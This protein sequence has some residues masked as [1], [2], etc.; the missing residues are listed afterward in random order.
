MKYLIFSVLMACGALTSGAEATTKRPNILHV[1]AD[2]HR[3]DCLGAL[4]HPVVKTPNLD[5]LV[6]QG[7][8][9]TNCYTMGSMSGAVCQPSRTMMLTGKSWLHIPKRG[10]GDP[11]LSLAKVMS[12][13]GYETWHCGKGGNEYPVGLKA[14][15]VN[16]VM[17]DHGEDK[18]RSSSERH[19]AAAIDFLSQRKADR[20]FYI[21]LAPP[22]PHDPR[23]AAPE[24]HRMYDAAAMPLPPAFLPHH[25]FDNG[26]MT[27]R[28]EKLAP[29]PRTPEDTKRQLADYYACITG[30][31]F[32]VGRIFDQLKKDGQWENTIVIFSGDNGLSIGDHGLFGKQNLY[33]FGGMHV[34]LVLSGPGIPHGT[35]DALVYLMDLFPTL[36]ELGGAELPM[37]VDA[38]SLVPVITGKQAKVRDVL[39]TGYKDCQRSIRD[40]RWKLIRY[41]LV[42][43]TQLFDLHADPHEQTN[44]ASKPQHAAQVLVMM[45]KLEAEMKRNDDTVALTVSRPKPIGWT[46]SRR[47]G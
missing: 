42:N 43:Y 19:A 16:V 33:E 39:Y 8:T 36:V 14:F 25:P 18:R 5:A 45:K 34:P 23:V 1:H 11:N 32:H 9:F 35:R 7:L 10:E 40:E 15:D 47:E 26:E 38:Q 22:V 46:P 3:A 6:R 13:A 44:L 4:G 27:V 17:D 21:Y 20:P 37:G 41:P 31:D 28:D 29:W 12:R 24:F 2:D 30:L